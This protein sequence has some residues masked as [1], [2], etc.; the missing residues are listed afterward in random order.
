MRNQLFQG[1]QKLPSPR[2][3]ARHEV[4]VATM[5]GGYRYAL[6]LPSDWRRQISRNAQTNKRL[7]I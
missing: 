2:V 6:R 7:H 1:L 3:L 5:R 4:L